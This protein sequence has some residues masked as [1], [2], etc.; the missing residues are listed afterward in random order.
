MSL[1]KATPFFLIQ[2]DL[3]YAQVRVKNLIG[4]SDYSLPNTL[5][6]AADI[7]VTPLKPLTT[8]QRDSTSSDLQ[9]VVN[10]PTV[11]NPQTGGS[12]V[13]SYHV[14][15]DG[16]S[17]GSIWT[18]LQ[19]ES[20]S[21]ST[22]QQVVVQAPT[23]ITIGAVYLFKYRVRT[24]FDFGPFSEVLN[25]YAAR[26][27]DQ[28]D[29]VTTANEDL[30]VKISW[31]LPT[32]NGGTPII[33]YR[34]MIKQEDD[35]FAE[36]LDYCNGLDPSI[37]ANRY[38][39]IPMSVLISSTYLLDQGHNKVIATVEALNAV[40]YSLPSVENTV[41]AS[42]RVKPLQPTQGPQRVDASTTD[43]TITVSMDNLLDPL[44]GGSSILSLHLEWD[45]GINV[46]TS[47]IG[48][49]SNS[50]VTQFTVTG[51]TPGNYYNFRYSAKNE[52]GWGPTSPVNAVQAANKAVVMN[53][54]VTSI[55]GNNV[56]ISWTKPDTK[57]SEIISYTIKI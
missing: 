28:I 20:G 24:S 25:L 30:S 26:V 39:H 44:N 6:S 57:G 36:S 8:P 43:T 12:P 10:I 9:L 19:G 16:A 31:S 5:A 40:G 2:G 53:A 42:V 33:G 15:Y 34:I 46:W 11:S 1:A 18:D 23:P 54:P 22:S 52:Y 17:S 48:S 32:Y 29:P 37:K 45:R 56:R 49:L 47:L 4:W 35:D 41:G 38:C 7:R 21:D 3:I 14:Q 13:L 51:L 50:M 55:S 27:T